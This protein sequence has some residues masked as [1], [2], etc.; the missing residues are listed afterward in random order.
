[1]SDAVK[2]ARTEIIGRYALHGEIASGGMAVVHFGKLLGPVGF[3]RPVAIK[4]LHPQLARDPAVRSMFLDEARLAS[5]IRHPNV[6]PTLDVATFGDELLLVMEYVDGE[7]LQNLLRAMR[8]RRERIPV[9]IVLAI[10]CGVLHGLH[11]AHEATNEGGQALHIVH[12]D[13]S[14][15]NIL[16]GVDGAS[17]VLDFG[18]AR[19]AER[20]ETTREGVVKGKLAYMAPEQLGGA[21]TDR[22]TDIYAAAVV[23]WEMLS[24]QRLF[25]G[26]DGGSVMI[27]KL[28]RGTIEPPSKHAP[29]VPKLLDAIT[30]HGLARN[31]DRRFATAREMAMALERFGDVARPSEVGPWVEGLASESLALRRGRLQQ[32]EMAS[33]TY[34]VEKGTVVPSTPRSRPP[35]QPFF[36]VEVDELEDETGRHR[37]NSFPRRL[38]GT[39]FSSM[40]SPHAVS[41][42]PR[43]GASNRSVPVHIAA[44]SLVRPVLLFSAAAV[45]GAAIV[46]GTAGARRAGVESSDGPGGT[47]APAAR[48]AAIG[49]AVP[50]PA[51]ACLPGMARIAGGRFFIGS[52]EGPANERPSHNVS[53]SSFCIDLTEVTTQDYRACSDGGDCKRAGTSREGDGVSDSD[54]KAVEGLCNARDPAGRGRHP[55]NCVDWDM[56]ATFC[57]AHGKRLPTEAEWEFAAG[58]PDG[59]KYPWGDDEPA[60][61]LLNAC[62][63][64]CADGGRRSRFDPK[65]MMFRTE[66]GWQATAPIGTFVRGA[67]RYGVQDLAGNVSEWVADWYAGYPTGAL[68][69]P[70]GPPTGVARVV[71]GAAWSAVQPSSARVTFRFA[72][73]PAT[74]SDSIGFRCAMNP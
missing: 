45:C 21:P 64:E 68:V 1:M 22:R 51:A 26:E 34:R 29:E 5:R 74:R 52:D 40:P 8:A 12:R 23:L 58:G 65:T 54:R 56:A 27:D 38:L 59:R 60:A 24:G 39:T 14:P 44:P 15:Q 67:S 35:D 46:L 62:G 71:R 37:D 36:D 31:P 28:L 47:F 32:V 66:D 7:S 19:A 53:V 30:L 69:D 9:R 55:I 18:I 42:S 4:R 11:A 61:A 70:A 49:G 17:R 72:A 3:C 73:S 33:S 50:P 16:C 41:L 6:V 13:V 48:G 25:V 2:C 10:M 43:D 20:A 63:K 57:H